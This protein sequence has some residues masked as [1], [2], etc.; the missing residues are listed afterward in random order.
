MS[1]HWGT[2][3]LSLSLSGTAGSALQSRCVHYTP[4]LVRELDEGAYVLPVVLPVADSI[5]IFPSPFIADIG[6][7]VQAC[8]L[9]RGVV[10]CLEVRRE[11]LQVAVDCSGCE[12]KAK[13]LYKYN[14]EKNPD[15]NKVMKIIERWEELK[16]ESSYS[17]AKL[18]SNA[19]I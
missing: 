16:E 2:H 12:H 15:R 4:D 6:Q 17:T 11:L 7:R 13:C 14:A 5:R 10:L 8:L 19:H 3:F 1:C 18:P 9:I